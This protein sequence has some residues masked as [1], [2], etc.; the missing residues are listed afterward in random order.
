[1]SNTLNARMLQ[2][3]DTAANW[4]S[5]N[6]TLEAGE[7]GFESDTAKLKIGPGAWNSL[8]YIGG[9]GD[10]SPQ[11]IKH[12]LFIAGAVDAFPW[13][14]R[15]NVYRA[16]VS[17][18]TAFRIKP[19]F[20]GVRAY[21][22][23]QPYY[24]F[25]INVMCDRANNEI[26]IADLEWKAFDWMPS[27][28]VYEPDFE[29]RS[30]DTLAL[31]ASI[32][33]EGLEDLS[34][35]IWGERVESPVMPFVD[36]FKTKVY[37]AYVWDNSETSDESALFTSLSPPSTV[38]LGNS[39]NGG[40]ALDGT[41]ITPTTATA[42]EC[43]LNQRIFTKDSEETKVWEV[44]D[45]AQ[46]GATYTFSSDSRTGGAGA[47]LVIEGIAEVFRKPDGTWKLVGRFDQDR[48]DASEDVVRTTARWEM[49]SLFQICADDPVYE[50]SGNQG[51]AQDRVRIES[52]D[53][54]GV[55]VNLEF[56]DATYAT[57]KRWS[58]GRLEME[59]SWNNASDL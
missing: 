1:M 37:R 39:Y 31:L 41:F 21:C 3:R 45:T 28:T 55:A 54:P 12:D 14:P 15:R 46:P 44:G 58:G 48:Y 2:R 9:G 10:S 52:E 35:S 38:K 26:V 50:A 27:V 34:I 53:F 32:I 24:D 11:I 40:S 7:I 29:F 59:M 30:G 56:G 47:G 49:R 36:E 17:G 20:E 16:L 57:T 5:S 13:L 33:P 43:I 19:G 51:Y 4:T 42:F 22:Y 8:A 6:P 25:T 18:E 23:S